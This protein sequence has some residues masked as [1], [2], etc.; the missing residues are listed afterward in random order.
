MNTIADIIDSKLRASK[1]KHTAAACLYVARD[2]FK[3]LISFAYFF[4]ITKYRNRKLYLCCLSLANILK[5]LRNILI[6]NFNLNKRLKEF[7]G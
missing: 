1:K 5:F 7:L 6:V 4:S 2:E 3:F